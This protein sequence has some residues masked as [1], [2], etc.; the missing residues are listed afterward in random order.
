MERTANLL[1]AL[2]LALHDRVAT[3]VAEAS[4]RSVVD[5]AAVNAVGHSPGASVGFVA[6][7]LGLT[8]AGAVRVID[9]LERDGLLERRD[10]VDGRTLGLHLTP[11]G[12]RIWRRQLTARARL[13]DEL[14][15][16]LPPRDRT[17]LDGLLDQLLDAL[18]T[19]V[20]GAEHTC[21]LCDERSCPQQ[22][23]PVTLAV[24]P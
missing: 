23:C 13:L 10:G 1:G 9:R 17:A 5:S 4:G 14:V 24:E 12:S 3:V 21:R 22:A 15:A 19:D 8:H 6:T 11:A 7:V 20:A 2:G 18:T 16:G